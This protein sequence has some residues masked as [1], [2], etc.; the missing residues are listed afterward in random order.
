MCIIHQNGTMRFAWPDV[1]SVK[2]HVK[3]LEHLKTYLPTTLNVLTSGQA[4]SPKYPLKNVKDGQTLD[5]KVTCL[6]YYTDLPYK[7]QALS[8]N[9]CCSEIVHT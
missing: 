5:M 3:A 4:R 2:I 9:K 8:C 1:G 7:I 6:F